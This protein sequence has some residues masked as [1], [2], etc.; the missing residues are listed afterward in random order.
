M[1]KI[2]AILTAAAAGFVL[3]TVAVIGC[4]RAASIKLAWNANAAAEQ[5]TG[6]ELKAAEVW[7]MQEVTVKTAGTTATVEGLKA[8][9]PYLFQVRAENLAG[10][11]DFSPA[12]SGMP[13]PQFQVTIQTS[14]DLRSWADTTTRYTGPA[15]GAGFFRLK[16]EIAP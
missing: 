5:V 16:I 14:D 12:L 7:G 2:A 6:Y 1:K 8:G 11:S 13:L 10:V 4:A 9:V 15:R 3:V